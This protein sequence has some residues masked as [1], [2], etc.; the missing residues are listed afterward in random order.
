MHWVPDGDKRRCP[1]HDKRFALGEPCPDCVLALEPVA[2]AVGAEVVEGPSEHEDEIR[3]FAKGC[4]LSAVELL[5]L[6][7]PNSAA[8]WGDL[9]LKSMRLVDEMRQRRLAIENDEREIAHEREMSGIKGA[10]AH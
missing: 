10:R 1:L 4:R 6:A 8:K 5:K 2:D 3:E 9:Y 7:E